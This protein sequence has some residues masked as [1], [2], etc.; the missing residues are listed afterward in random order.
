M[1]FTRVITMVNSTHKEQNIHVSW[2]L[3]SS[4]RLH[5]NLC[6]LL[7]PNLQCYH[8]KGRTTVECPTSNTR[9]GVK[10]GHPRS[11]LKTKFEPN[12][13]N[14]LSCCYLHSMHRVHLHMSGTAPPKSACCAT[15]H[16]FESPVA[17][18]SAP[19]K[20]SFTVLQ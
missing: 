11:N 10:F 1:F 13:Q 4:V 9:P 12:S 19:Q 7:T 14:C 20:P 6:P 3:R 16:Y 17:I 5:P 8:P 18:L 15:R 2:L